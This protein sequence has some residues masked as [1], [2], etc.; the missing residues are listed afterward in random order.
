VGLAD[1]KLDVREW[2]GWWCTGVVPFKAAAGPV[3]A[4]GGGPVVP[5]GS[6]AGIDALDW[7]DEDGTPGVEV[8]EGG[9]TRVVGVDGSWGV[10]GVFVPE[11][12]PLPAAFVSFVSNF[13]T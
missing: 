8:C 4:F 6:E 3:G 5:F 11:D 2:E 1:A 10:D 13:D 7:T 12:F 9:G